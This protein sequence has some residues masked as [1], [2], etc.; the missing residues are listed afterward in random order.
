MKRPLSINITVKGLL[1]KEGDNYFLFAPELK[2][3]TEP[4]LKRLILEEGFLGRP[5]SK[6]CHTSKA[7]Y[8]PTS[9]CR[10]LWKPDTL[11]GY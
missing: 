11:K 8:I 3:R 2:A 5:F 9:Q 6:P 4:G 10:V 1:S 7:G